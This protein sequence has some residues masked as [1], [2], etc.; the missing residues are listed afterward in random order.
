ASVPAQNVVPDTPEQAV[1]SEKEKS[2][3]QRLTGNNCDYNTG[4]SSKSDESLKT[5]TEHIEKTVCADKQNVGDENV[6][7]VD[8][9]I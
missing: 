4:V 6:I 3:D 2:P 1:T 8:N 7:D 9:L 5:V